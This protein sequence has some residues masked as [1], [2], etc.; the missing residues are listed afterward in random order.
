[1][2]EV[3][4][5]FFET[6]LRDLRE[7][8]V[9]PRALVAG[10]PYTVAHLASKDERVEWSALL[11]MMENARSLWTPDQ[12][13]RLGE[14]STESPLV[15]FI[16]VVARIRFSV[17]GFYQW[18]TSPTGVARQMITCVITSCESQGQGRL[19]VDFRMLDGYPASEEFFLITQGTYAAMPRMLGAR[20]ARLTRSALEN[21]TRFHIQYVEPRGVTAVIRRVVTSPFTLREAAD[22]L[23]AAHDSLLARYGELE[24]ARGKLERQRVLLDTA[25]RI[26]QRIWGERDLATIGDLITRSLVELETIDGAHLTIAAAPAPINI[27]AGVTGADAAAVSVSLP[28][29]PSRGEIAVWT[30]ADDARSLLELLAPTVALAVDN[31]SAYRELA[32]YQR[33]LERL[34]QERTVELRDAR[35][36]L[37]ATVEQLRDALGVRERFFANISHEFRTP[38]SLILIAAADNASR[39]GHVFDAR[40]RTNH[41]TVIGGA[42]KLVRLVDELLLLAAG[43]EAKL[44]L[45]S[46]PTDLSHLVTT[47]GATWLPAAEHAGLTLETRAPATLTARVDAVAIERIA[48]NLISNAVKFTP[49]GGSVELEL[50]VEPDGVRFSVLDTGPGIE[51]AL[52]GRL[53]GR[54]ERGASARAGSGIGLSL[55]KQLVEAHHGTIAAISRPAGGTELRVVLPASVVIDTGASPARRVLDPGDFGVLTAPT[56]ASGTVLVPPGTSAGTVL[57]A[58][59]DP[60]L[61]AML[62]RA[63]GEEHKV[64]VA[65]D[66]AAA[67]EL[68]E[69]HQPE[70]LI[71][72]V[73]MPGM[74]GI[75]LS[76]RFR[77]VTHD[78]LA[79]IIILSAIA[80]VETRLSGLQAGAVDYVLK[81]FDPRELLAR[82]RSQFAMR[83]LA[84]RLRRAEQLAA[85]GSLAAGLAHELRNPANGL[86]NAVAPLMERLPAAITDPATSTGKLLEVIADCAEQVTFLSRQLLGFKSGGALELRAIALDDIVIRA[87]TLVQ[88]ALSGI[89]VRKDLD[90]VGSI[91]CSPPLLVQVLANLVEN[92]AHAAGHGGWIE[93]RSRVV[94]GMI[95]VEI[96]DSGPG[97]PPPLRERVFDAFYTTKAPGA[98]TGLGL[99]MA[100]EIIDR[101]GGVLEIRDRGDR[102]VFAVQLPVPRH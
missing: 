55:V 53:F 39:V 44:A 42:R 50:A 54:F 83:D 16:G 60:Q 6:P 26:G 91:V 84:L 49:R 70:L 24:S 58:E 41:E 3:S 85:M 1:M 94:D 95:T 28:G 5:R 66:G 30:A 48:T 79:P 71:T 27:R 15:Q 61:A 2:K 89:A 74:D 51:P 102:T 65:L 40:A 97:V 37:T 4:C 9:D 29:N 20:T 11:R 52:R 99:T 63:L 19:V 25:Y 59:D 80:D 33:G 8:G 36:Q 67:L 13:V 46:E 14:R 81:P 69:V 18:V 100:R 62:A 43:D 93:V 38:L 76:R 68:V 92:A 86:I 82:V 77:E 10:T 22:E 56:I 45:R 7:R 101:H 35:D 23:T 32:E 31:A 73:D 88:P 75:E 21:G 34:V 98:G 12:L 57:I 78:R 64:I 17:S 47:L 72:D 87:L 90:G 96:T